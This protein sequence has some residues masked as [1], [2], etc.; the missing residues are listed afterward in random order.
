MDRPPTS[1]GVHVEDVVKLGAGRE[2]DVDRDAVDGLRDTVG[3]EET[4]LQLA[5]RRLW[6][7]S[8]RAVAEPKD[9]P[10]ATL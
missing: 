5:L 7:R 9:D 6:Q 10:V 4:Q 2:C 3:T 1:L 8:D